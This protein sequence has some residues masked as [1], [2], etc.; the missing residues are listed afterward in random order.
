MKTLISILTVL[1]SITTFSQTKIEGKVIDKKN[2]PLIGANV[3]IEGT[4][5]E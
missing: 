4:M 1:I 5:M 3:F 2:K